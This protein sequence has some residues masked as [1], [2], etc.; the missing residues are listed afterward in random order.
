MDAPF[1]RVHMPSTSVSHRQRGLVLYSSAQRSR[2]VLSGRKGVMLCHLVAGLGRMKPSSDKPLPNVPNR[3]TAS[4]KADQPSKA[5][6]PIYIHN[7]YDYPST[8]PWRRTYICKERCLIVPFDDVLFPPR[9]PGARS[10][11]PP[12]STSPVLRDI[13]IKCGLHARNYRWRSRWLGHC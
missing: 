12:T 7:P 8:P 1:A 6:S 2:T 3:S 10:P 4:K 13:T 9:R 5:T 11:P